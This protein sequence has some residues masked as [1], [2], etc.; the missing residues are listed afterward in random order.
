[1]TKFFNKKEDVLDIQLTQYGKHL[2]SL[3]E[4]KPVYYAFFDDDV[5]YDAEYGGD[6]S[7]K[8]NEVQIRIEEE[9]PSPRPQHVYSG[10]ETS[11]V[12]N[13]TKIRKGKANLRDRTVQ[14][15]PERHYALASPLGTSDHGEETMPAWKVKVLAGEISS[16][17][18]LKT[19]AHPN[20][21]TPQIELEDLIW[22]TSSGKPP[23]G[24]TVWD[25]ASDATLMQARHPNLRTI[26]DFHPVREFPDGSYLAIEG[27]DII[28]EIDEENAPFTNDNFDI[29]IYMVETVDMQGRVVEPN[30]A[31]ADKTLVE[32]LIP[33]S[34]IKSWD[35]IQNGILLDDT[36]APDYSEA[37]GGPSFV[38][39]F[40]LVETDSEIDR[41]RLCEVMPEARRRG[42]LHNEDQLDCPETQESVDRAT[43][44]LYDPILNEGDG[45]FGEDC[46]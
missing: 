9:T 39:H 29:E 5:L 35:N 32:K 34:F 20:A 26:I 43:H 24:K 11:V 18:S 37:D 14:Q 30:A 10:R 21:R 33:L 3:G 13:N 4:L 45:P 7:E 36:A 40:L 46:D 38:E 28:L 25:I 27:Q 16:A 1:V 23:A 44:E 41:D 19:G 8:Q 15:T 31:D 22:E 6:T 17:T 2:L 12:K 42:V